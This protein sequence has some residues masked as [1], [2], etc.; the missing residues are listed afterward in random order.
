MQKTVLSIIQKVCQRINIPAPT[1]IISQTDPSN[2]QLLELLIATCEELRQAKC[3]PQMK[4]TYTFATVAN[5]SSYQLP[6]DFYSTVPFTEYDEADDEL[7]ASLLDTK[8]AYLLYGLSSSSGSYEY[9]LVGFDENS[10]STT[11]QFRL[12]PTPDAAA[13]ITFEYLSRNFFIPRNWAP[14]VIG[15]WSAE[16]YCNASGNIY[17]TAA[18]GFG[19]LTNTAPSHTSGTV[20]D[21]TVDWT[22][23]DGVYET[24]LLDIDLCVF[25]DDLVK[26]GLRAKFYEDNGGA[27]EAP[28]R[29]FESKIAAAVG[30]MIP[31]K[32]GSFSRG[33]KEPRFQVPN[34]SWS[35]T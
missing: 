22:Y 28:K 3:W 14:T 16:S 19:A 25:D 4:R 30:R 11:G 29:E 10:A 33:S 24:P 5:Q 18:G 15:G 31:N 2:L 32:V 13:N 7:I 20:S 17:Y 21:G 8:A 34:K 27:F 1:S 6:K 23:F 12:I 35:L 26:L 9:K